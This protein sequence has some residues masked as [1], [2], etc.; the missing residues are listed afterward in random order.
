MRIKSF[1]EV[2]LSIFTLIPF[3]FKMRIEDIHLLEYFESLI[4]DR[5]H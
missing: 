5:L 1:I 2:Q 3:I 4:E